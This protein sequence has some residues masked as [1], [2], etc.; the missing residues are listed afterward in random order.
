[1]GGF[2]LVVRQTLSL[3]LVFLALF[4]R[5]IIAPWSYECEGAKSTDKM[6][7]KTTNTTTATS[8]Q[9]DAERI[10]DI[11]SRIASVTSTTISAIA[12]KTTIAMNKIMPP[13][14]WE[15]LRQKVIE[16][17]RQHPLL[18]SLVLGEV[19][20][21]GIPVVTYLV[22]ILLVLTFSLLTGVL[23]A[24]VGALAFT[25]FCALVG[26]LVLLPALFIA[27]TMSVAIWLS[28]WAGYYGLQRSGVDTEQ[29]TRA[30]SGLTAAIIGRGKPV[31]GGKVSGME[32][33]TPD[34]VS[35][36]PSSDDSTNS[37]KG[38][39]DLHPG[40]TPS[41]RQQGAN[42]SYQPAKLESGREIS[43]KNQLEPMNRS[44]HSTNGSNPPV[45]DARKAL[46]VGNVPV[47]AATGKLG[48]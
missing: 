38:R 21:I 42:T 46:D 14:K 23:V 17:A 27:S 35:T 20:F 41:H 9:A 34:I 6:T 3:S 18:A 48:P 12:D 25:S 30:T 5:S 15:T 4:S 45:I 33:Q 19:I 39:H 13:E 8:R 2:L 11:K 32:K 26:L 22:L 36:P 40:P 43:V 37:D 28:A 31:K 47:A 16:I 7:T 44:T 24:V 29:L 1:L 10:A